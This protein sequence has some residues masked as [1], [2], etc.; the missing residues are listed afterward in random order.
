MKKPETF[1]LE[2]TI[3]ETDSK[4]TQ[5]LR[6]DLRIPSVL[7]GPKIEE[8]THFSVLESDI[9]KM[10]SISQTKLQELSIDGKTYNT[11]LKNVDFDPV[12][13]RAIHADFYVLDAETPVSLKV[14]IKLTGNAKGV[15]EGGGRVYQALRILRIKVLP[16]QIPALFEV[17][18][19]KLDIGQSIHIGDLDLENIIPIDDPSRTI[20]TITPPK[21]EAL[22]ETAIEPEE[23]AEEVEGELAEGEEVAEG[24]EAVETEESAEESKE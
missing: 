24:E 16:D 21:S 11:L 8:N 5:Q 12:T 2:G 18:I 4:T 3:R 15:V 13:D 10:L 20:V 19:T 17:D 6:E 1:K 7:Y 9:D 22:F 14:P 23:E